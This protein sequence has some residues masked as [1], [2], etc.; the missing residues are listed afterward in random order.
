MQ[1]LRVQAFLGGVPVMATPLPEDADR[2]YL[3]IRAA[4]D[5]KV[6]YQRV[7]GVPW[8]IEYFQLPESAE[9]WI[10]RGVMARATK[11]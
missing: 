5:A 7:S 2:D 4:I 11:S 1:R 6:A 3:A 9:Q 8:K 10:R